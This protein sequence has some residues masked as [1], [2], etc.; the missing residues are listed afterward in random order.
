M[1]KLISLCSA[2][3]LALI[4]GNSFAQQT[5]RTSALAK[6]PCASDT[7]SGSVT[8]ATETNRESTQGPAPA[9]SATEAQE[10]AKKLSNPVASLISGAR[11]SSALVR[12]PWC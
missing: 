1:R 3:V 11:R 9:Q 6:S 10:L 12:R 4:A 5:T 8:S 2:A 7:A